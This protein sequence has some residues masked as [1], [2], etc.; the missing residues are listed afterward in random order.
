MNFERYDYRLGC[1]AVR[2]ERSGWWYVVSPA[3]YI[4]SRHGTDEAAARRHADLANAAATDAER[5]SWRTTY[6]SASY[7]AE[8]NHL[9]PW[10]CKIPCDLYQAVGGC[11]GPVTLLDNELV[12]EEEEEE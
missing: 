5:Q 4:L 1:L 3:G 6:L 9:C 10:G 2:C 7:S 8:R 11:A 12:K